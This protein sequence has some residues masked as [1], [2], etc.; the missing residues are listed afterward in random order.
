MSNDSQDATGR[1]M[2]AERAGSIG[3]TIRLD[4][5]EGSAAVPVAAGEG[6][7]TG[8]A[9]RRSR[10]ERVWWLALVVTMGVF[11]ALPVVNMALGLSTK[12]Y[13]LWIGVG[14]AEWQ[15]RD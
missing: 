14:Q 6:E 4:G 13:E 9:R 15:G 1:G 11:S 12:D 7:A 8:R 3:P 10:L 2:A 5:A